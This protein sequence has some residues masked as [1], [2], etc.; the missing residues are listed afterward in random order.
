[1]LRIAVIDSF[2]PGEDSQVAEALCKA[3]DRSV[4]STYQTLAAFLPIMPD[5][6][7]LVM[8]HDFALTEPVAEDPDLTK[9]YARIIETIPALDEFDPLYMI[10]TSV[11][12]LEHVRKQGYNIP[13]IIYTHRSGDAGEEIHESFPKDRLVCVVRKKADGFAA[14]CESIRLLLKKAK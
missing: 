4:V 2:K 6:N 14:L 7:V 9:T 5:L 13:V 8:E 3:F 12:V 1:M 10:A 11:Y